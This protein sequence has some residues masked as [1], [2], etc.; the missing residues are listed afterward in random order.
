MN[1]TAILEKR[2]ELGVSVELDG[3][4]IICE[5]GSRIPDELKPEIRQHKQEIV[6]LLHR[7]AYK[8]HFPKGTPRKVEEQELI[9]RVE[10]NGVVLLWSRTLRD[11]VA[12]YDTEADRTKVPP[13][14]IAYSDKEVRVLF[15]DDMPDGSLRRVH[16]AKRAGADVTGAWK[17][18]CDSLEVILDNLRKGSRWLQKRHT[19]LHNN[20]DSVGLDIYTKGLDRWD[21]L[22]VTLRLAYVYADCIFGPGKRCPDDSQPVCSACASSK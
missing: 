18:E 9:R 4:D 21:G 6:G 17:E 2:T 3:P 5:P 19:T 14:F 16:D 8:L 10:E 7:R 11:F 20:P 1:A 13:G 12:I 15:S 22:E